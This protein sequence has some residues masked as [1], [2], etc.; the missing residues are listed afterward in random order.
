MAKHKALHLDMKRKLLLAAAAAAP[1]LGPVANGALHPKPGTDMAA[2]QA[3][4][5]ST[6]KYVLG[7]FK[8]EGDVHD[9]EGIQSRVLKAW[10]GR[11]FGG[12][13]ELADLVLE[14]DVRSEF[15]NRGYFKVL[16]HEPTTQ[17]LG[18]DDGKQSIRVVATIDEGAQYRLGTVALQ[19]AEAGK[20][21]SISAEPAGA[22]EYPYCRPCGRQRC[23]R[24]N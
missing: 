4:T 5:S 13:K 20:P 1:V 8:L 15:Q 23:P 7:D 2:K 11:E 24:G 14:T 3:A 12:A 21:L 9:R 6:T 16:L 18:L 19:S 17:S 10:K 22:D